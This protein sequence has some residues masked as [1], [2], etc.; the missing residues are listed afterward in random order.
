VSKRKPK[1]PKRP[2]DSKPTPSS[3]APTASTASRSKWIPTERAF[4]IRAG[5]KDVIARLDG[6]GYSAYVV[7]GSVRDFLLGLP[8]KDYDI[9][10]D[11]EP[12]AISSL[13]PG[14]IEVGKAFGVLKIPVEAEGGGTEIVEVATFREDAEYV[15]FRRPK[16]VRFAGPEEDAS[17]RDFT[18][19]GLFYDP[20]TKRILD[21]VGGVAD[22]KAKR[23]RAIGDANARLKEDALRVLRAVRFAVRFGFRIEEETWAALL[24]NARFTRKVSAERVR[25]EITAMLRGPRPKEA[26]KMLRD[27][28]VA[29]LWI[30]EIA[31]VKPAVLDAVDADPAPRSV[32]FV[33]ALALSEAGGDDPEKTL[34]GACDRLRLSG[35]EKKRVVELVL[36]LPKFNE[37]FKMREATLRRWAMEPHFDELL[38]LRRAIAR[39]GDGNLMADRFLARLREEVAAGEPGD[40]IL[41]GAD[42]I[43][44]GFAPGPRFAE[45]LRTVEDLQMEKKLLSKDE[46]LEYV[47]RH[48]VR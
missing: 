33:F 25:D 22:L 41:T 30:P 36:D 8:I 21:C 13:F 10:T 35:E 5:A 34:Q 27:L 7:G 3:K 20:K 29:S 47:V 43:Q 6:A 14:A 9:A 38:Q 42:L 39:A 28:G 37:A 44:L 48:F 26:V 4:P 40:K 19:N 31:K 17:R 46:A 16:S 45:I 23:V 12:D 18:I 11:A 32:A 2:A 15:D 24:E 1:A